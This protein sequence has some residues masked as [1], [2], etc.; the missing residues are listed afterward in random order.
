MLALIVCAELLLY[1][2]VKFVSVLLEIVYWLAKSGVTAVRVT[3]AV[4]EPVSVP[5]PEIISAAAGWKIA[6]E[7]I[8]NAPAAEK[9]PLAL[10]APEVAIVKP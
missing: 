5:E 1:S 7:L 2:T 10:T 3:C 6:L 4:P 9:L 8:V